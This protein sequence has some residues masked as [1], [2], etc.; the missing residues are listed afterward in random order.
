MQLSILPKDC[1]ELC[2]QNK[3][4][5]SLEGMIDKNIKVNLGNGVVIR[6]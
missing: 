2:I 3:P 4:D 5:I 1:Y 6:S